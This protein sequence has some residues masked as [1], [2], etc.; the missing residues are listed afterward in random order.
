[1]ICSRNYFALWCL[2]MINNLVYCVILSAADDIATTFGQ[3]SL[4]GLISWANNALGTVIKLVNAFLLHHSSV[5]RRIWVTA[6]M[7]AVGIVIIALAAQIGNSNAS[8]FIVAIVGITFVGT[9]CSF[10]E[11]ILLGYLEYYPSH[12]VG[13][14]SAGTGMSGVMGSLMYLGFSSAGVRFETTFLILLVF[15]ALYLIFFFAVL[16][17]P[18]TSLLD[19]EGRINESASKLV[20][21]ESEE[22]PEPQ[23]MNES[24]TNEGDN[25][26]YTWQRVKKVHSQVF[27]Y[28]MNLLLVYMFEY[29]CQ[30]AAPF[31]FPCWTKKSDSFFIK[32]AFV[33][34]QFAYQIGVLKSRSSLAL[35]RIDKLYV[36][37]ALQGV[38]AVFWL[39]QGKYQFIHGD[40]DPP[41]GQT[42]DPA[43]HS[44][45]P[46]WLLYLLM[47]YC[48]L[49]GGA[50]YVNV[51]YKILNDP[52]VTE[53][54]RNLAMN[55]TCIY[56]N[57]GIVLGSVMDVIFAS[58]VITRDSCK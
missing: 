1:M 30:F 13:G 19:S 35:F 2:G 31:A 17:K 26:S 52:N 21:P 33:L 57:I 29:G 54:D 46:I 23:N 7:T 25:D 47:W 41:S 10:G 16:Q 22:T 4:V 24:L 9:A 38:N 50:A 28:S 15:V 42:I 5:S 56:V 45:G 32:N 43:A 11:I 51:F 20:K 34:T 36:M 58:A 37:T 14:W 48:G 18:S 40:L 39:C 27:V 49:L 44:A 3:D 12:L 53:K 6:I 55:I 8:H